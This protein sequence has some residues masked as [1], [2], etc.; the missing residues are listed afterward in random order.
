[1]KIIQNAAEKTAQLTASA[2]RKGGLLQKKDLNI[3]ESGSLFK[4]DLY[5]TSFQKRLTGLLPGNDYHF[6]R[7]D[8]V[9]A[10]E[11][12]NLAMKMADRTVKTQSCD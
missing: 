12:I 7:S 10:E 4:N 8:G 5:E 9:P 6:H 3:V 11:G 1:M 2:C